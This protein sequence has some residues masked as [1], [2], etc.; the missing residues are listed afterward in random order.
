MNRSIAVRKI[1]DYVSAC[2]LLGVLHGISA[3]R[4]A[5]REP[6]QPIPGQ[7]PVRMDAEPLPTHIEPIE[8]EA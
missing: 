5:A 8:D 6:I 1:L 3:K 7:A 2:P 4:A